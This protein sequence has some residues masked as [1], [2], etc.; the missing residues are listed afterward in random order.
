MIVVPLIIFRSPWQRDEDWPREDGN[1]SPLH[2]S[3]RGGELFCEYQ[4][5]WVQIAGRAVEYLRGHIFL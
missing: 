2:L 4:G 3:R 5:E 1:D